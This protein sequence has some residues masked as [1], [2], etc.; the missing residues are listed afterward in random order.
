MIEQTLIRGPGLV[1]V[2]LVGLVALGT[3]TAMHLAATV[4][5]RTGSIKEIR[6]IVRRHRANARAWRELAKRSR[7]EGDA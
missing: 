1:D 3:L 6:R 5:Y 7:R 4:Y 2:I